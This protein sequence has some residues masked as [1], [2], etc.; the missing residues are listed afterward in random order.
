MTQ[1]AWHTETIK[2]YIMELNTELKSLIWKNMS[3]D[4]LDDY[5]EDF[6]GDFTKKGAVADQAQQYK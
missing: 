3:S 1:A 2:K 4:I 5:S 6:D